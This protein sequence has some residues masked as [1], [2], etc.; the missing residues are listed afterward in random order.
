MSRCLRWRIPPKCRYLQSESSRIWSR[1]RQSGQQF[2]DRER[3]SRCHHHTGIHCAAITASRI[4]ITLLHS[5]AR[6]CSSANGRN[7]LSTLLSAGSS[8]ARLVTSTLTAADGTP[9]AF[10]SESTAGSFR[11]FEG[12]RWGVIGPLCPKGGFQFAQPLFP[13]SYGLGSGYET[14]RWAKLS[15]S[16]RLLLIYKSL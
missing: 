1:A 5:I 7:L 8:P 12:A 10:N 3:E 11:Y 16:S 15:L 9:I 4:G 13:M 14:D 6:D 2:Q